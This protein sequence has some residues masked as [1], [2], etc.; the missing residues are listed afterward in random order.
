MH[1]QNTSNHRDYKHGRHTTTHPDQ[2]ISSI[3]ALKPSIE[4]RSRTTSL[5][6]GITVSSNGG[7]QKRERRL[8]SLEKG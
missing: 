7:R 4:G 3:T 8:A 1:E 6:V 5:V 2:Q